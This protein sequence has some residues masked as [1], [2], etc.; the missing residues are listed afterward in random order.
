MQG[1][2]LRQAEVRNK[3]ALEKLLKLRHTESWN[4]VG[5]CFSAWRDWGCGRVVRATHAAVDYLEK[6][7]SA[8]LVWA[9]FQGWAAAVRGD[10]VGG[11]VWK[12]MFGPVF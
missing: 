10:K 9:L 6:E 3:L 8:G 5:E 12:L 11:R 7:R 1:V 4:S 2:I